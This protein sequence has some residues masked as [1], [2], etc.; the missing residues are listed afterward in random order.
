MSNRT[1]A[2]TW[3]VKMIHLSIPEQSFSCDSERVSRFS[4]F[5]LSLSLLPSPSK[6]SRPY[7]THACAFLGMSIRICPSVRL[8]CLGRISPAFP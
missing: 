3:P 2:R 1:S 4:L 7:E 5:S 8:S 6:A